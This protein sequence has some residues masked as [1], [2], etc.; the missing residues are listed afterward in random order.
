M[1]GPGEAG[2]A[3]G[4]NPRP[5]GQCAVGAGRVRRGGLWSASNGTMPN[6]LLLDWFDGRFLADCVQRRPRLV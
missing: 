6:A 5:G 1:L 4:T 3:R 2:P